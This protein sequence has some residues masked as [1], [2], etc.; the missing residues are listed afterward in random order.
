MLCKTAREIFMEQPVFLEL[1]APIKICGKHFPSISYLANFY[2]KTQ[3]Y[4]NYKLEFL[5]IGLNAW[6]NRVKFV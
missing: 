6:V 5:D 3:S 4:S 2:A 1:E